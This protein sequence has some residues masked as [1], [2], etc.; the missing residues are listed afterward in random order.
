MA[1]CILLLLFSIAGCAKEKTAVLQS[2]TTYKN[3]PVIVISIDT[4]RS[5]HLPAYGYKGVETPAIDRFRR[6]AVLFQHAYSPCPLTLPSHVSMLTGQLPG[7]H[8][9]RNNIGFRFD[10]VR[11]PTLS[12]SL[13]SAGYQ[14]GAA[15][16][17]F[18]LRGETG[19]RDAFDL[20]DDGLEVRSGQALGSLQR[21]GPATAAVASKWIRQN[22]GQPFFFMLHLFEPHAPYAPPAPYLTRY[23]VPYDGEIAYVDSIVGNFLDELRQSGVYD[24]AII[25]ILSDHG[26]GLMDHG[27]DEHGIFLYREAIQVPLLVKLPDGRE[28]GTSVSRAVG[29]ID[30]FPTICSLV[31]IKPPPALPGMSLFD[32]DN[33]SKRAI[34]S[35]TIYPRIHLGWSELRSL[36]DDQFHFIDAP[37]AELFDV[38]ADPREKTNLISEQRRVVA[39]MRQGVQPYVREIGAPQNIDPREVEKLTALGYLGR[40]APAGSGP[41]PD[42]K[43][44]IHEI[45][46]MRTAARLAANRKFEA[47]IA[48]FVEVLSAN[49]NFADA[50]VY[51]G[52]TYEEADQYEKAVEAYRKAIELTPTTSGETALSLGNLYL[53]MK[54]LPEAEVHAQ[55]GMASSRAA[56]QILLGRVALARKQMSIA[57]A[58][59]RAAMADQHYRFPAAVLLAQALI[60]QERAAEALVIVE[61]AGR[62]MI[63]AGHEPVPQ[64]EFARGDALAR[65]NRMSEA[66]AAFQSEIRA[67]PRG[68]QAYANL[69][70]IYLLDGRNAEA[71]RTLEAMIAASSSAESHRLAIQTFEELGAT[72][73][74]KAWRRKYPAAR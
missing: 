3:A 47:A 17:A 54:R 30:L 74:A 6:D 13:R 10:A 43:D 48:K 15:V 36:V 9:V 59:A 46:I 41:L 14:S 55:L 49:P 51:L 67:F 44:R 35:E 72:G 58:Q 73:E 70:V 40:N 64:L 38:R 18:V 2:P 25:V 33:G 19:L 66:V 42:P 57:E 53:R 31:G 23:K 28:A 29:L 60:G 69:A 32:P 62:D 52:R 65:M 37:R 50:W 4:L 63:A 5:D 68:R 61:Q 21:A 24:K 7:D 34:F 45:E 8:G 26:E 1:L 20:Y 27:E 22:S 56:A 16:S 11:Q 71:R 12:S 39:A